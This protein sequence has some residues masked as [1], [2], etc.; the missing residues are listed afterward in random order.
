[1][2][3]SSTDDSAFD[4][5]EELRTDVRIAIEL[6]LNEVLDS[7]E[8]RAI[9]KTEEEKLTHFAIR[10]L[11]L[12]LTYS[13]YLA[14]SCTIASANR[15]THSSMRSGPSFGTLKADQPVGDNIKKLRDYFATE[16]F[17]PDYTL[18]DIWFT[19]RF[20]FL[21]DYYRELAPDKYR[22]LYVH[23]LDLRQQLWELTNL[24]ETSRTNASLGDFGGS[25]VGLLDRSTENEFRY[26]VSDFHM[27]LSEIEE[28]NW[29]KKDVIQGTD[30][31][32]RVYSKLTHLE[33][34]SLEQEM[35]LNDM[36]DFFYDYVWKYPALAISAETAEGPNAEALSR[37]RLIELNGFDTR[38][39][40]ETTEL[41]DQALQLE[42]LPTIDEPV[43]NDS[44]KSIHL[45]S[46]IK[47]SIDSR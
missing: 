11:D 29:L 37:R 10:D 47:E 1:M 15:D 16:E 43:S 4:E 22:E 20:E 5:E 36:H 42:L 6:A 33:S 23:S 17:F 14:G 26:V 25:S 41:K 30:M 40:A 28:L 35:L 7:A 46:A 18:R 27:D 38:L 8:Q 19:N 9:T 32:E 24:I 12:D 3:S 45:H 39:H 13:W 44:E 34:I 21:R 31:L 2:S